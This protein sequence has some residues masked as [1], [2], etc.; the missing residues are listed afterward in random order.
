MSFE[1]LD[2]LRKSK[3]DR[4]WIAEKLSQQVPIDVVLQNIQ[5]N[6]RGK[7]GHFQLG[8]INNE[9]VSPSSFA[10]YLS[11]YEIN[12]FSPIIL[13]K[14]QGMST[15]DISPHGVAISG[16]DLDE[17]M[18]VMMDAHQC[19]T[20]MSCGS[21]NKNVIC[22]DSTLDHEHPDD[23]HL[24]VLLVRDARM[25]AFPVAYLYSNRNTEST[26]TLIFHAIRSRSGVVNCNVFMSDM[27]Y[28]QFFNAWNI[29]MGDCQYQLYN[30]WQVAESFAV[31]TKRYI[32][33]DNKLVV[34]VYKKLRAILDEKDTGKMELEVSGLVRKLAEDPRTAAFRE[35]FESRYVACI[36]S[37]AQC[38]RACSGIGTVYHF[39]RMHNIFKDIYLKGMKN[40]GLDVAIGSLLNVVYHEEFYRVTGSSRENIHETSDKCS[41]VV[42]N[43]KIGKSGT[44]F[45]TPSGLSAINSDY[46]DTAKQ[47]TDEVAFLVESVVSK[48]QI[49]TVI[50]TL[51]ALKPDTQTMSA[52]CDAGIVSQNVSADKS[53]ARCKVLKRCVGAT[54]RN[55]SGVNFEQP[56]VNE[57]DPSEIGLELGCYLE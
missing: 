39:E 54:A 6:F 45:S 47:L 42:S 44:K 30:T 26:F 36:Q 15:F 34:F 24:S 22:I 16:C 18:F 28:P 13:Y 35:F 23:F 50:D 51:R 32:K 31:N 2:E 4:K 12:D 14:R 40:V 55:N 17:F 49:R 8:A 57:Q 33:N 48:G 52:V 11:L 41:R 46:H 5:S 9:S 10:E 21:G 20:L 19:H 43:D 53:G 38:Y 56:S 3:S 1:E 7:K 29:I 25:Q 37:W 27:M